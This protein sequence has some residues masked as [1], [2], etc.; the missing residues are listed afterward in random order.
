MYNFAALHEAHTWGAPADASAG[1]WGAVMNW[2]GGRNITLHLAD[3]IQALP[4]NPSKR[5]ITFQKAV[6]VTEGSI[7]LPQ[8]MKIFSCWLA[9]FFIVIATK[10]YLSSNTT[11]S[12]WK[13]LGYIPADD[14]DPYGNGLLTRGIFRT[15]KC[16]VKVRYR[17]GERFVRVAFKVKAH[18]RQSVAEQHGQK[19][20][21][22]SP[23]AVFAGFCGLLNFKKEAIFELVHQVAVVLKDLVVHH[24]DLLHLVTLKAVKRSSSGCCSRRVD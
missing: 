13:N 15:V 17:G 23:G 7:S 18:D 19:I 21:A 11:F 9:L 14:F 10:D 5:D 6:L 12:G 8:D 22:L 2:F 4:E 3:Q 24:E 20:C 1:V 16:Q